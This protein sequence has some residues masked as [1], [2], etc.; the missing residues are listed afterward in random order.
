M[1]DI[2][3]FGKNIRTL[4]KN[5][6]LTLI[7]LS[8]KLNIHKTYLGQIE[9][10]KKAPSIDVAVDIANYFKIGLDNDLETLNDNC[11]LIRY[12]ILNKIKSIDIVEIKFIYK[13]LLEFISIEK[14]GV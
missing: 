11:N 1:F 3:K 2:K 8:M 5:K 10:G 7:G 6:H 14:R 13:T 9:L 12:E 4:R